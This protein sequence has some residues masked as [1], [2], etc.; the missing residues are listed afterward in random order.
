VINEEIRGVKRERNILHTIKR[1]KA[2]WIALFLRRNCFLKHG[3]EGKME[4]TGR[5][6]TRRKQLLDYIKETI[7]YWKMKDQTVYLAV[8]KPHLGI[9]C[10]KRDYV[11]VVVVVVMV[12]TMGVIVF[13]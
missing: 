6:G 2:N 10:P 12:M 11:V 8:W 9:T 4:G 1:R 5:R 13:Q 3:I 7:R